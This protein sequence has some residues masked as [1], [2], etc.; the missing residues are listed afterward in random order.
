MKVKS[1][2]LK[3]SDSHSSSCTS[4]WLCDLGQSLSLPDPVSSSIKWE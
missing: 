3:S 4:F 2:M 1:K